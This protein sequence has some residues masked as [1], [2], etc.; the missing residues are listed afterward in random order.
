MSL[1]WDITKCG[2]EAKGEE[3][4][5]ITEA[6]IWQCLGVDMSGITEKNYVEFYTRC[7]IYDRIMGPRIHEGS[8]KNRKSRSFTLAEIKARI[9]L[10]TNCTTKSRK[11]FLT[12]L[13]QTVDTEV[14]R[15]VRHELPQEEPAH[16]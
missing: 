11:H 1:D 8:G 4:R 3:N 15:Q 13:I 5:S 7:L 9:G 10:R 6:L 14:E 2:P 12:K 16:V